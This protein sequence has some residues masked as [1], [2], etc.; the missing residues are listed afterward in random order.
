MMNFIMKLIWPELS[1]LSA[2]E[3]L[4]LQ[5]LTLFTL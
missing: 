2:L 5:D 3:Y 4:S 1:E